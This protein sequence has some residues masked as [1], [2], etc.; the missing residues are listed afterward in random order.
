MSINLKMW[1][2]LFGPIIILFLSAQ[3]KGPAEKED[4]IYLRQKESLNEGWKFYKYATE[5]EVDDW[6]INGPFQEGWDTEV[7]GGM[8]RLRVKGLIHDTLEIASKI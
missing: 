4:V 1:N 5:D 8:G 7:T 6:A 2:K 3:C